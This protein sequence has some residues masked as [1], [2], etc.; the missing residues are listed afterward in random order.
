MSW[1]L[2][3]TTLHNGTEAGIA[4]AVANGTLMGVSDGSFMKDISF[5]TAGWVFESMDSQ[6]QAI[7]KVAVPGPPASHSSY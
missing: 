7:G 1:V 2:E 3:D 5:G 6:H 4:Q